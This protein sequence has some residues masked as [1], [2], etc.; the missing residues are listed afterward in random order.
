MYFTKYSVELAPSNSKTIAL[1]NPDRR[2]ARRCAQRMN[3]TRINASKTL[4]PE[5]FP[6]LLIP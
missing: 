4:D 5:D 1:V 2:D 6:G 3:E